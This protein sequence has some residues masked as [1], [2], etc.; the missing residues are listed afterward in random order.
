MTK[1]GK[2]VNFRPLFV[3]L[4]IGLLFDLTFSE[5]F[6]PTIGFILGAALFLWIFLG[7]YWPT[8]R[9][10]F[11]YWEID[12][13]SLRY[14][15]MDSQSNRLMTMI[16]PSSNHLKEVNISSI[17]S[18]TLTGDLSK[19]KEAPFAL[20]YSAYL[21]VLSG[22]LSIIRNPIDIK[23]DLI[24]GSS[25][26]VSVARDFSYNSKETVEKLDK[27]FTQLEEAHVKVI[28]KTNHAVKL[29]Y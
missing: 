6:N 14:S 29:S 13:K 9:V 5:V 3:S 8:I 1:F 7:Y 10:T 4:L 11:D 12:N 21:G 26:T 25:F 20:P 22:I 15:N 2:K 28:D 27:V 24:D 16:A 19:V 18:A 23:F 17:R